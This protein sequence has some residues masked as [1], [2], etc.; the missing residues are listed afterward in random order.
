MGFDTFKILTEDEWLRKEAELLF[1][2]NATFKDGRYLLNGYT[3]ASVKH[4]SFSE[5]WLQEALACRTSEK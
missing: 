3:V 4:R 1:L 2:H 5:Y